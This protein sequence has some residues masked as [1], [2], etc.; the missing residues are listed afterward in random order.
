MRSV[1][2][3]TQERYMRRV[4]V[5]ERECDRSEQLSTSTHLRLTA[6]KPELLIALHTISVAS[7]SCRPAYEHL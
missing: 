6:A 1:R 3:E 2:G 5:N 7:L 4:R